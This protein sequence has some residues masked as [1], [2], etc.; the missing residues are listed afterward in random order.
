MLR[1]RANARME[2]HFERADGIIGILGDD[3]VFVDNLV[4]VWRADGL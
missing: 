2:H 3:G 4:K 1:D